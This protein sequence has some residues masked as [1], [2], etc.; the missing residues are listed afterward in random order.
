MT[1]RARQYADQLDRANQE[2]IATVEGLSDA[3][4]H[5]PTSAEGWTAGVVAHHVAEN[6][7]ALT[8]LVQMIA[9]G[10]APPAAGW[11]RIHQANAEHARRHADT[12]KAETLALLR[13]N[14]AAAVL[15]LRGLSDAQLDRSVPVMGNAMTAAQAIERILIGH[16][17]EHHASIRQAGGGG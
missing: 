11:D 5:A 1:D 7:R 9:D 8:R 2:L 15:A 3:G 14:G 10:Q 16:V 13:E 12:T 6:H 4:W 17:R